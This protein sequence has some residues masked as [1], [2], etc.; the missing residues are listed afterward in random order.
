MASICWRDA[1]SA[2]VLLA[3][4]STSCPSARSLASDVIAICDDG[5]QV[6]VDAG[7]E[8]PRQQHVDQPADDDERGGEH[9]DVPQRQPRRGPFQSSGLDH[10]PRRACSRRRAR[11][12]DQLHRVAVID[13]AAQTLDVDLDQVR[14]RIEAVVPDVLGDVGAADD[15]PLPAQR[16]IRAACIPWSS[17]GSAGRPARRG[18]RGYRW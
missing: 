9:A 6:L 4:S 16:D 14:Q 10:R 8:R 18:G 11:V 7:V 13:L 2:A 12:L 1:S 15:L 17:A 3:A 5:V